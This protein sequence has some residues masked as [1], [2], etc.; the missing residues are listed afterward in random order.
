MFMINILIRLLLYVKRRE[1]VI[2]IH[3]EEKLN[4]LKIKNFSWTDKRIE[5]SGQIATLNQERGKYRETQ[6]SSP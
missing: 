2:P 4:K 6:A 3:T 1:V 5:V